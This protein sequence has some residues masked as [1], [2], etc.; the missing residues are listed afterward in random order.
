MR[1]FDTALIGFADLDEDALSRP[2]RWRDGRMDVRYA[3][4]RTLE[5][6][7]EAL[8]RVAAPRIKGQLASLHGD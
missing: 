5:E 8:V 3:L 1:E 4:Y 7:Q 2:W 6:A